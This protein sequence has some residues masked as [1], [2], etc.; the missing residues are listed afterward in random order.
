MVTRIQMISGLFERDD[1][2]QHLAPVCTRESWWIMNTF[3]G[4]RG[5]KGSWV[6]FELVI[7]T[8]K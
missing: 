4:S 8:L 1:G 6:A 2:L 3:R 5:E 7:G